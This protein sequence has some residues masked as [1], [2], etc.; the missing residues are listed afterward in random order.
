MAEFSSPNSSLTQLPQKSAES[1]PPPPRPQ[2]P[3]EASASPS[4]IAFNGGIH[5]QI[6]AQ[7]V[8]MTH[9]DETAR[10]IANQ[11]L[12]EINRITEQSRFRRGLP[13]AP[14]F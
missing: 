12:Q 10:V 9:A 8:D 11:V 1:L 2:A 6:T 4:P 7:T 5:V 13:P 3:S 14:L